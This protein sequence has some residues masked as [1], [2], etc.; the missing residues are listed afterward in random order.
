M[1]FQ[2]IS[3]FCKDLKKLTKGRKSPHAALPSIICDA[4]KG[5]SIKEIRENR[6]M[7]LTDKGYNIIKYRLQSSNGGKSGGY[8]LIYFVSLSKEIAVFLCVY[9]KKGRARRNTISDKDIK[10]LLH[11][12]IAEKKEDLLT[13][14]DISNNLEVISDCEDYIDNNEGHSVIMDGIPIL[15]ELSKQ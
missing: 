12:L 8:R 13:T 9:P 4:L 6:D 10:L 15:Q 3:A 2:A 5:L 7:V 1:K 14:Y 11:E